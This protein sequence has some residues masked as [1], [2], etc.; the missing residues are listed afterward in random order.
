ML[1]RRSQCATVRFQTKDCGRG[2]EF[3]HFYPFS[4]DVLQSGL[5]IRMMMTTMMMMVVTVFNNL[6]H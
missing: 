2:K 3:N 1:K 4:P 5:S 6:Y